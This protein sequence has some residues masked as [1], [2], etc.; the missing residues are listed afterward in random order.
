MTF[1]AFTSR[2]CRVPHA[3]QVHTRTFSGI[4]A[5]I[6]PHTEHVLPDIDEATQ[7]VE[8]LGGRWLEPGTTRELDGFTWRWMADPEGNEFD[9]DVLP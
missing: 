5:V 9:I 1:A 3:A 6:T 7:E 2:S 4:F 8:C